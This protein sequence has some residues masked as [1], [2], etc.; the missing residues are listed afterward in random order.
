MKPPADQLCADTRADVA[1]L[2]RQARR[3]RAVVA[4]DRV[5]GSRGCE[6]AGDDR[7]HRELPADRVGLNPGGAPTVRCP[8]RSR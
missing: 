6:E 1:R 7:E 3:G 4:A 5:I 2:A 8:R